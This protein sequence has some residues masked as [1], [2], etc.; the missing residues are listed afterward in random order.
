L[1]TP[2]SPVEL[3]IFDDNPA[4]ADGLTPEATDVLRVLNY[5]DYIAP[6]VQKDFG[7]QFG[8]EV[9]ITPVSNIDEMF[10]KL[11]APGASFDLVF[12]N[13]RVMSRLVYGQL[14]QPLNQTYVP[15]L[16]NAWPEYQDP[17]YDRG[18]RY[19]VPYTVYT[20]GVGY[21][22]DRVD[23]PDAGYQ[24]IWDAQY[25][26]KVG[27]I[28]D[29]N[30]S[31]AMAMLAFD[32]GGGDINTDNPEYIDAAR[33][34]LIELIDLVD[35]KI[36]ITQYETIATGKF[37]VHQAWSGDLL[38]AR[39]YLPPGE[40]T[41]VLGYWRPEDASQVVIGI[42]NIAV[43]KSASSPVLAHAFLN[44]ILDNEVSEKNFSW[45]GYQPPLKK[46]DADYLIQQ[47]YISPNLTS[48]LVVPEDFTSGKS[49]HEQTPAVDNLWLA[50]FQEFQSGGA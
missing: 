28:D 15:N 48:A 30:E 41:E 21:R 10:Q 2:D 29:A 25:K 37:T 5:P 13:P 19:S 42:D 40:T 34:K 3:P 23:R 36:G 17:W 47:G 44:Y 12:P 4:I 33:D 9:Q 7:D 6:G 24:M 8:I 49:F 35:I 1:A 43:P 31:L 50:A 39:F 27:V 45:N 14:L 18:A 11:S 20:T 16:S 26:G 22:A 32:I 38:A 46:L